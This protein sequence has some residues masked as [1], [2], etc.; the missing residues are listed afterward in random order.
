MS[1]MNDRIVLCK[2][3]GKPEYF[4]E[5]RWLSGICSCRNCYKGQYERERHEVYKWDDLD[6]ERPTVEAYAEQERK[7]RNIERKIEAFKIGGTCL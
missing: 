1:E 5:M 7:R 4:G 6:G 3:C 2:H